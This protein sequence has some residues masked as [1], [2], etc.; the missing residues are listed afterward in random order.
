MAFSTDRY[1]V[2]VSDGW[3][4]VAV[5]PTYLHIRPDTTAPWALCVTATGAPAAT[6]EGVHFK[7]NSQP[8]ADYY[9]F[10]AASS[11]A[12][13]YIRNLSPAA[14]APLYFGVISEQ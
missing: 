10:A 7:P 14:N 4:Q 1:A 5:N 2:D 13:F 6:A 12:E 3:V 9:E 8:Q 11:A